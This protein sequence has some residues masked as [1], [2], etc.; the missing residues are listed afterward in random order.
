MN[1]RARGRV[2]STVEDAKHSNYSVM[3][4]EHQGAYH[5]A[6]GSHTNEGTTLQ[7]VYL[8]TDAHHLDE[9]EIYSTAKFVKI[10]RIINI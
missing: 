2:A 8:R 9:Q 4:A 6:Q 7:W 1:P 10:N 3:P 5:H